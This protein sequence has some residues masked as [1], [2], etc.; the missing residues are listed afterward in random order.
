M[1]AR[2]GDVFEAVVGPE[3][4]YS[5]V[6]NLDGLDRNRVP[7]PQGA[8]GE[9][10]IVRNLRRY[11]VNDRPLVVVGIYQQNDGRE[12]FEARSVYLLHSNP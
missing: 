8:A 12:R 2:S 6:S 3:T 9:S 5:V 7:D 4:Y 1:R 11:A 10:N